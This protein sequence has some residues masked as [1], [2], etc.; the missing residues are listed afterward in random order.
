MKL[1][2]RE[3]FFGYSWLIKHNPKINWVTKQVEM[4]QCPT[5]ECGP[6]ER[7]ENA[8]WPKGPVSPERAPMEPG[9][10]ILEQGVWTPYDP[11]M[12]IREEIGDDEVIY[13]FTLEAES[14]LPK[15][16]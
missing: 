1:G 4:T 7:R 10:S 11:D 16:I 5:S 8:K 14:K 3:I 12:A 2:K 13:L 9:V 15:E 6:V